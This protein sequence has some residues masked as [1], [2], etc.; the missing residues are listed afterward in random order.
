MPSPIPTR[1][2]NVYFI[3]AGLSCA[4]G[5]PNTAG[6]ITGLL[7]QLKKDPWRHSAQLEDLMKTA[8]H[9]FYPDAR[10]KGFRPDTVDF[11]SAVKMHAELFDGYPGGVKDAPEL[12]RKLKFGIAHL[13]SQRLRDCDSMLAT[14]HPYLSGVVQKGNIVITSNWDFGLERYA[15]L[16]GVPVRFRGHRD[17]ELVVLELHGSIDWALGEHMRTDYPDTDFATLNEQ[18]FGPR[19]YSPALPEDGTRR[20]TVVRIRALENWT[21]AWNRVSS[22]SS[23]PFLV[24]MA[25]GKAGDLGP[26]DPVWSD[27]YK[28]LSRAKTLE[29]VGYSMPDDDTEI[30]TLLRAGIKRG[31]G[32]DEVVVRNP[33]PDVHDRVR[34]YLERRITSNYLPVNAATSHER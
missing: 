19:P 7:D 26:L 31:A 27:A 33:S 8:F 21:Q 34:R 3:G 32:P 5:L 10:D 29:I 1:D 12:Y 14:P 2:R 17:T 4:L 22:R 9:A 15:E 11:F 28:A 18:L 20:G 23:E 16:H 13:L 6:L 25:R 30:R 24:T